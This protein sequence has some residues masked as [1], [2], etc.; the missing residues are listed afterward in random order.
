MKKN[1]IIFW[2]TT[3][4]FSLMMM[5]SALQMLFNPQ[6]AADFVHLGFPGYFRIELALAKIIGVLVLTIPQVPVRIKEWAYAGFGID[7]IS[8]SIA[9]SATG[10][11]S[12]PPQTFLSAMPTLWD[13]STI[14]PARRSDSNWHQCCSVFLAAAW[15]IRQATP[16]R[17][18]IWACT[19]TMTSR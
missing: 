7:L 4:V 9:H 13:R 11:R 14:R 17:T 16:C 18:G 8:A 5:L 12:P 2:T 19:S 1:K 10:F 15:L 3:V 6:L